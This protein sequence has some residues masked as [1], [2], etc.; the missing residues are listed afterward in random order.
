MRRKK[1]NFLMTSVKKNTLFECQ[2]M[3]SLFFS[4]CFG[5]AQGIERRQALPS[6]ELILPRLKE[7]NESYGCSKCVLLYPW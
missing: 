7:L 4:C 5:P 2:I 3:Y 6:T 1:C